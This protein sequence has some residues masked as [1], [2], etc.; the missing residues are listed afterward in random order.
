M[1]ESETTTANEGAPA[2]RHR[3]LVS[4]ERLDCFFIGLACH[5]QRRVPVAELG[6]SAYFCR[7]EVGRTLRRI[8][9]MTSRTA[10]LYSSPVLS[11]YPRK[12][13]SLYSLR[14]S[15]GVSCQGLG[16]S[17]DTLRRLAT[18]EPGRF[19]SNRVLPCLIGLKCSIQSA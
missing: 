5:G 4:A 3:P 9:A 7:F 14:P 16:L 8:D 2:N 18:A 6:R 10:V 17:Q 13:A 1:R 19:A 15:F 11:Q 12:A